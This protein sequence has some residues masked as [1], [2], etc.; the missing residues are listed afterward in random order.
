MTTTPTLAM[1]NFNEPFIIESDAS[2]DGI[3]AVL[4]QHSRPIAFMSRALGVA[5]KSWSVYAKEML[6]IV[7]AV[8]TWRPYLLGRKFYIHTDQCSLKHLLNSE[9]SLRNS[10]N[11]WQN[12]LGMSMKLGT[13]LD[14][15]TMLRMHFLGVVVP[16]QS[17]IIHQLLKE[18]HDSPIGGH[19]GILRTYK[20]LVQQF[21]WPSM[22]RSVKYH[23]ASCEVCQR[24]KVGDLVF[25]K[26]HPYQPHS[27]FKRAYQKLASRFYCPYPILEKIGNV[28]YKLQLPQGSRIHQ[29]FHVSFL[30]KKIDATW[31][32]SQLIKDRFP[33]LKLEDKVAATGGGIDAARSTR[34]PKR[35]LKIVYVEIG[36]VICFQ[37]T[38]QDHVE[39]V[40]MIVAF[41]LY[42]IKDVVLWSAMV[43]ACVNNEKYREY[44]LYFRRILYYGIEA[45]NVIVM[46]VLPAGAHLGVLCFVDQNH[47][48]SM[49][50][51]FLF[52]YRCSKL[53]YGRVHKM[54][55]IGGFRFTFQYSWEK[56]L[57]SWTMICS[58]IE[59]KCPRKGLNIF[60]KMRG[61]SIE[62]DE[63]I[64]GDTILASLQA[65]ELS[66]IDF[67]YKLGRIK[68]GK[69]LFDEISTK[70]SN[71]L[72][73]HD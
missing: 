43:L 30:K 64:I 25:L 32:D 5:K 52:F 20:R 14:M 55:G 51:V 61:S 17:P 73:F 66:L 39:E 47:G 31:E 11:G 10:R 50:R 7:H 9:L 26:L 2:V 21:Y 3:G 6:T 45:N 8:C 27:V 44:I 68:R 24:T 58:C 33:I 46:S 72:E 13:N 19:S 71:I 23:V 29:V 65:N 70:R 42:C 18:F 34:V 56:D 40:G 60:L 59:N 4:T 16:P 49:K 53:A 38:P 54:W 37:P 15:R 1:P 41:L 57:A 67:F 36:V 28:A 63:I 12:W 48:F 69:T 62:P 35:N 22:H